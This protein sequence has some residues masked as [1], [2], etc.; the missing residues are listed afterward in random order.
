METPLTVPSEALPPLEAR[1]Q[2]V[3]PH[4]AATARPLTPGAARNAGFETCGGAW[5]L[6]VDADVEVEAAWVERALGTIVAD[7]SL[8]GVWGRIE[9]WFVDGER[10]RAGVRDLYRV[11]E[12]DA[13]AEYLATLAL[14]RRDALEAVAGYEPRL[15]S[16]EDFEQ[17][18]S[19]V[20]EAI[21]GG[22]EMP[23]TQAAAVS[24]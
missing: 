21:C 23:D 8:A 22:L 10:E 20:V 3:R 11:G 4:A 17:A 5:V 13:D 12:T 19:L 6:F 18:K 2:V 16:E 24:G 14:Y 1:W 15:N 9:E 7:P